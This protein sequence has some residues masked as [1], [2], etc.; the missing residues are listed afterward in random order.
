VFVLGITATLVCVLAPTASA[1]GNAP[2][3]KLGDT[4]RV[5][6]G[7][8]IADFTL[9]DVQPTFLQDGM[10]PSRGIIW[11]ADMSVHVIKV[12]TPYVMAI[13]ITYS[14]VTPFGD[15]YISQHS[16]APDGLENV[17]INAPQGSTVNGAVF[18]DVYRDPMTNVIVRSAKTGDHLAQW[19]LA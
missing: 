1:V 16:D 7:A 9:I 10:L 19:N 6:D 12:P 13:G 14:G 18:F 3:G 15:A 4:L 5:N 17:L 11:R 8:I 2:I